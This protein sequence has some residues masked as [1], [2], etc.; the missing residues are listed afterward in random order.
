LL[1]SRRGQ[2]NAVANERSNSPGRI[3]Y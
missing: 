3:W 1:S 2:A